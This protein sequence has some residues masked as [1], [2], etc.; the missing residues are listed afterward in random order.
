MCLRVG[1][2]VKSSTYWM[3][4]KTLKNRWTTDFR[5]LP[6]EKGAYLLWI[7]LY[8]PVELS[9]RFKE[10]IGPGV[11]LYAGSAHGF[12]GIHAR[13]K[14]HLQ[15]DKSIRWH[16]DFLTN[17]AEDLHVLPFP[18]DKECQLIHR[19]VRYGVC[20]FPVYGFGNSDCNICPSHLLLV[21]GLS[22]QEIALL[23]VQ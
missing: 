1:E 3:N 12:G 16:V 19:L 9:K 2:K 15:K 21:E 4:K 20:H 10:T 17:E 22:R 18:K 5:R 13:C 7:E 8:H 6:T 14:R 23:V 11:F